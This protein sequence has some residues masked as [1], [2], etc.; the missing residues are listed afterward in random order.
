MNK[1]PAQAK[2]IA[3]E[4][5]RLADVLTDATEVQWKPAPVPKPRVDTAERSAGGHGDP[6]GDAA[7]DPRRLALRAEVIAAEKSLAALPI[8]LL[9]RRER[10]ER[11]LSAWHGDEAPT[12]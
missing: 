1:I 7:A 8:V 2:A 5:F 11:A 9:R 3:E 4:A 6:T 12:E 10:L